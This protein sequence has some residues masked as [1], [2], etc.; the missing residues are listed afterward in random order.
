MSEE[1]IIGAILT[2]L[3]GCPFLFGVV[4]NVDFLPEKRKAEKGVFSL[5]TQPGTT[6]I[7]RYTDGSSQRQHLFCL[8][9][10][11]PYDGDTLAAIGNSGLYEQLADWMDT[12]TREGTLPT[13][14]DGKTAQT[15]QAL[16]PG[17]LYGPQGMEGYYLIQCRMTYYQD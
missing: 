12:A 1:T 3:E 2:W 4:I 5:E 7:R 9:S 6:L 13:L 8:R 15:V 11:Q 17:Y 16:S 10:I 14:P